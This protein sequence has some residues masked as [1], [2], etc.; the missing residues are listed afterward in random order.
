MRLAVLIALPLAAVLTGC[1]PFP[2]GHTLASKTVVGKSADAL[3]AGDG[4]SCR[5]SPRMVQ[6]TPIG[7]SYSCL[8]LGDDEG[9]RGVAT[10][11][12]IV[13]GDKVKRPEVPPKP[14]QGVR[15]TP[16]RTR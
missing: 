7:A 2:G 9:R 10:Q 13:P 8:W 4:S 5:T 14:P 16:Q 6:E 12:T 15:K 1:I 3:L 11:G